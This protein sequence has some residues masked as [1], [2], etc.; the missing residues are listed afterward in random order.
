[1]IRPVHWLGAAILT[2]CSGGGEESAVPLDAGGTGGAAL[3]A[4]GMSGAAA[5][6]ADDSGSAGAGASGGAP[7]TISAASLYPLAIGNRW[8]YAITELTSEGCT[9][10]IVPELIVMGTEEVDG[11]ETFVLMGPCRWDGEARVAAVDDELQQFFGTWE[12]ALAMP[13]ETGHQWLVRGTY[14]F[15]WRNAGLVTVPAGT[16]DDCWDR[17]GLDEPEWSRT[18]CVGVGPVREITEDRELRL[19]SYHLE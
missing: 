18:Y 2:A 3:A 1:M 14:L 12:T 13:V 5:A 15:E 9:S 19:V 8:S 10:D 7:A 4:G 11:R 6:M 17:I 16:F